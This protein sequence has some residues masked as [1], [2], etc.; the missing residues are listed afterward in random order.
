VVTLTGEGTRKKLVVK[1][2]VFG[3]FWFEGLEVGNYTLAIEKGGYQT[4]KIEGISTEKDVNLG[5]I[6]L[7]KGE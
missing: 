1:T 2:D 3:D 4:H 5:D 7:H 6:E